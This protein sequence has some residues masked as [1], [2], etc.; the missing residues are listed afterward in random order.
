ML[1]V[2]VVFLAELVPISLLALWQYQDDV[3]VG[4]IL[5]ETLDGAHQDRFASHWQKLL[6]NL[7]SHAEALASGYY[8]NV[9]HIIFS[10][11]GEHTA[12]LSV[13]L[14]LPLYLRSNS[15][16][17]RRKGGWRQDLHP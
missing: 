5:V 14:L 9:I 8:D 10:P 2:E 3:E 16:S 4:I 15:K 6:G 11:S 13:A 7:T 12:F 17:G 1:D